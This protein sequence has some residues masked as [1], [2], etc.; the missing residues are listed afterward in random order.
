[1]QSID[2]II[3][4]SVQYCSSTRPISLIADPAGAATAQIFPIIRAG[5]IRIEQP[6]GVHK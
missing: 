2:E 1:M 6:M 4:M 3:P 5:R